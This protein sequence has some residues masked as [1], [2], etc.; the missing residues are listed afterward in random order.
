MA[1]SR[2]RQ[3]EQVA[4]MY[5]FAP[6]IDG[7]FIVDGISIIAVLWKGNFKDNDEN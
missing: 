4:R 6:C 2:A 1:T 5:A 7:F 3:T